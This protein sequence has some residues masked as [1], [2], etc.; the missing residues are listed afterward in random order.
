MDINNLQINQEIKEK[1]DILGK[2]A[3]IQCPTNKIKCDNVDESKRINDFCVFI[4]SYGRPNKNK[5]LRTLLEKGYEYNQD[6]YIICS[7]DDKTLNE[8]KENYGDRLLIFNKDKVITHI[9]MGDNFN[10]KNVVIFARIMSLVFAQKMGYRFFLQFDDDY[11]IFRNR[12]IYDNKTLVHNT[13]S[14]L[15]RMFEVHLNFL[16]NTSCTI[17]AMAQGG[18]M[19][20]GVGNTNVIKGYKRKVMNSFFCDVQRPFFFYGTMNEDA[21]Y[22]AHSGRK[23]ILV[24]TLYGYM[25]DQETTQQSSGG[26]TEIY[27]EG[28][29]YLKSFYSVMYSPSNIKIG[30]IGT[31]KNQRIHH[32]INGRYT[33]PCIID[34]KYKYDTY[35][36]IHS[37]IDE[38]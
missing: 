13:I 9:D 19:I 12:F 1:I 24:L 27:L 16:K 38:W 36:N 2:E 31:K 25:L 20:G 15:D 32:K 26:L 18:D 21:T 29:T 22:Y 4:L 35:S 30:K 6:W 11:S 14:N 10:K 28:G 3:I 33:N 23:G 17:V 8:Y 34:K 5:T 7:D 37:D